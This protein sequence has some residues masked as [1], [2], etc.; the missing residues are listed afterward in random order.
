MVGNKSIKYLIAAVV[1]VCLCNG[2]LTI[3]LPPVTL[4]REG[5]HMLRFGRSWTHTPP[6]ETSKNRPRAQQSAALSSSYLQLAITTRHRLN[7]LISPRRTDKNLQPAHLLLLWQLLQKTKRMEGNT[8]HLFQ[9]FGDVEPLGS[10]NSSRTLM[11]EHQS[12]RAEQ[13]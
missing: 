11:W 13:I 8:K 10:M 5:C 4:H 7:A 9:Q 3:P 2:T 6:Q 12:H 1:C